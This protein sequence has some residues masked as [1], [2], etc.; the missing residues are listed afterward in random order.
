[1]SVLAAAYAAFDDTALAALASKG[2]VRRAR[3]D[4]EAGKAA[5]PALHGET[6][7]IAADGE[8][9]TLDPGGPLTARCTC[10]ATGICRHI[11][12]AVMALREMPASACTA[13][14][15]APTDAWPAEATLDQS[16]GVAADPAAAA[17][18]DAAA[19]IAALGEERLRR[20]AASDWPAAAR[21]AEE[22][23][24]SVEAVGPTAAVH[25]PDAPMPVVFIAGKGLEG[26]VFKGPARRRR[27]FAT[28]AAMVLM[29]RAGHAIDSAPEYKGDT[30]VPAAL[31]DAAEE[32]LE[33]A[34]LG[35]AAGGAALAAEGLLDVAISAR[36]DAAPRLASQLR[37]L[38]RRLPLLAER[39]ID[40]APE[41]LM[42][43]AARSAA[44][45]A[46]LRR[47][48]D[49]PGLTGTLR[50]TYA[51]A[52]ASTFWILG[53]RP[54]QT[55]AGAR[56]LSVHLYD[57][58]ERRWLTTGPMRAAGQDPAFSARSA[59]HGGLWSVGRIE[60]LMGHAVRVGEPR[61]SADGRVAVSPG[62]DR[63]GNEAVGANA[64]LRGPIASLATLQEAG[65]LHGCWA[66]ARG[67]VARRLGAGLGRTTSPQALILAPARTGR[68][69][70][71]EHA[72][73]YRL[74]L[75]DRRGDGL[76]V[77]LAAD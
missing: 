47:R 43:E 68:L 21:L 49:D 44:L 6:V 57:P 28:A 45:V 61:V 7:E 38:S 30:A 66:A 9:V 40:A 23:D 15:H 54:W 35:I 22:P 20:F 18:L 41:T 65:A 60:T 50:R 36:A 11:L 48:P 12:L 59:Y 69:R 77:S 32:A 31:L 34:A 55:P 17:P 37:A 14:E 75:I 8:T 46:A 72:Q 29:R 73:R 74:S 24:I 5:G 56:G 52:P 26:A 4:M 42:A 1:M 63:R 3:R 33:R 2:L 27:L 10:P 53:A 76:D 25:L 70:L 51:P 39:H 16:A 71:D 58:E 62:D 64:L 67:E 13:P 19:E